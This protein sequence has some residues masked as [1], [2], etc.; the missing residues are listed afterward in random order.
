MTATR[1]GTG[2]GRDA[3]RRAAHGLVLVA[4]GL[5]ILNAGAFQPPTTTT[6]LPPT[7]SE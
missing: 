7:T 5:V 6:T 4:G 2:R 1:T 3:L